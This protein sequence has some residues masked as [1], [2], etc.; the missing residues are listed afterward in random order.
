MSVVF[1]C[2]YSPGYEEKFAYWVG[3]SDNNFEGDFRWSDGLPFQYTSEYENYILEWFFFFFFCLMEGNSTRCISTKYHFQKI[4]EHP[5][6][7]FYTYE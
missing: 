1:G 4:I 3:G 7:Q 5:K 6:N 2:I